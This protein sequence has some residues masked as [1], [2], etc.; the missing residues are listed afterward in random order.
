[1]RTEPALFRTQ[2][3]IGLTPAPVPYRHRPFLTSVPNSQIQYLEYSVIGGKCR[4]VF[5]SFS[6]LAIHRFN[7]VSCINRPA[8]FRRVFEEPAQ[9]FPMTLPR[10]VNPLVILPLNARPEGELM[11][12]SRS[13]AKMW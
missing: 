3:R 13:L 7:H 8:D 11:I 4:A 5:G 10:Q 9:V 6:Q 1:M 12:L 2:W